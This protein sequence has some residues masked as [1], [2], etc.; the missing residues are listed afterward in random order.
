M[1]AVTEIS[2]SQLSRLVG[3]PEA[4]VIVDVR[5]AEHLAADP[6]SIPC[7]VRRDARTVSEWAPSLAGR[8]VVVVCEQ[9]RKLSHGVAAFLRAAGTPAESLEGGH[10]AWRDAGQ[11]LV[12]L[13]RLPARDPEGRTRWV[14]RARPKVDRS[15]CPWLIRRFVD[16]NAL[17]LFGPASEVAAVGERFG[18]A[19]FDVEGEFF[20]H[21]GD[22]CTFDTMIDEFGLGT[23]PLRRLATIVRGA[24][25][26][27]PDLAPECAGLLAA[28]LGF[29]R[30][31]REDL[32]QLDAAM[33]LYDATYRWCRDATDETHNWP[34]PRPAREAEKVEP[35]A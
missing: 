1:P 15:A 34:M 23:E 24:D 27:R 2:V 19:P 8:S 10:T 6:R 29:S 25:T 4:P 22:T 14:T 5:V 16:A 9:G 31:Y 35:R 21:R 18:A 13:D 20:S 17:F 30:M 28:S 12:R 3:T 7:A 26:A 11:L 33:A 32:P